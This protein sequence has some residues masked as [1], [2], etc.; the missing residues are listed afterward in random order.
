LEKFGGED[1]YQEKRDAV[2]EEFLIRVRPSKATGGNGN[3]GGPMK[4]KKGEGGRGIR[5]EQAE[6][7]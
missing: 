6:K 4:T 5:R 2:G 3:R 1:F 7:A